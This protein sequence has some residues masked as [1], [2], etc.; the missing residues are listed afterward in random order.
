MARI[1]TYLLL[2][3][4]VASTLAGVASA[5]APNPTYGTAVVDGA[6]GEWNLG[7][8]FFANMYRAGNPAKPIESKAYLRY[9]CATGTV[10]VLV[11]G[12]P[13]VPVLAQGYETDA[14]TKVIGENGV[15]Y[16]GNSGDDGTPPD[17][18]WVGLS[19]D[20][21]TAEGYEAS[22]SLPTGTHKIVIHVE[23][24]DDAAGQ[25]S[26]T[27]GFPKDGMDLVLSCG[28]PTPTPTIDDGG[29]GTSTPTA[30]PTET[31]TGT[32]TETM[33]ETP[34]GTATET[35]TETVTAT[36]TI[37]DGGGGTSTPTATP[38]GTV[39]E[40]PAET[41][42][43]TT[44]VTETVTT[45]G[46]STPTPT[47]TEGR[48][49]TPTP[50]ITEGRTYTPT[51]TV[52]VTGT[53]T[54][55]VK[56]TEPTTVPTTVPTT[57][58]TTTPPTVSPTPTRTVDPGL[59]PVD[60]LPTGPV[61]EITGPTVITDPGFYALGSGVVDTNLTVWLDIR[62]SNV[63]VDGMGQ[64]IDGIDGFGTY[65]IRVRGDGPLEN[66]T[67]RNVTVTDFAY[68]ISLYDTNLS[69]I[70][71]V[72]ASSNTYDGIMVVGGGDNR[73]EC[74][75]IHQDD[76][77][78]NMTATNRTVVA[79]NIVTE[80]VRGSGI[81]LSQGCDS[82]TIL[83]NCLVQN[84]EGIEIE[85]AVNS[86]L[87]T[88]R[89]CSSRYFGLNLSTA[90][91][92][93]IADNYFH[94]TANIRYPTGTFTGIWSLPA[95]AGPNVVGG[96][97]IGGNY[98]GTPAETGYSD[99]TPDWDGDGFVNGMYVLPGGIGIDRLPLAPSAFMNCFGTVPIPGTAYGP[100]VAEAQPN[101]SVT[102]GGFAA[103]QKAY[104]VGNGLRL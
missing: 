63:T 37:D 45:T 15:K 70:S 10:Y 39:T 1:V 13:N 83:N 6:I 79:N 77:G 21:K 2:L 67:I 90:R 52:T 53:T 74:S 36:P 99:V 46:T 47:W 65:G 80:N 87:R 26:A 40:T 17:F 8:D 73:I 93:T 86:T 33:T 56:P 31:V 11:L 81:H 19:Q 100:I 85:D 62:V 75:I 58:P 88:N 12:E 92:L 69:R 9:D 29:G 76:D 98:W 44:T 91:N 104:P 95:Q 51:P 78:I 4:L 23:V 14:W 32:P 49:Y 43:P 61:T 27:T 7:S 48:T 60:P 16:D 101:P 30:T 84:D 3:T 28:T 66:I 25:T 34:T 82:V 42:T 103:W 96:P 97:Y 64:I 89:I 22:Y 68:G 38:T 5:A 41:A 20:G 102:S 18:R 72:S 94:N 50:T 71:R 57:I 35:P 59:C 24:Y 54:V 55:P